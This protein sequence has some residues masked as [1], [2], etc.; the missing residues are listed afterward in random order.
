MDHMQKEQQIIT[1][2]VRNNDRV[3]YFIELT[4]LDT[5][6]VSKTRPPSRIYLCIQTLCSY[7][8]LHE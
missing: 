2:F 4:L 1:Q 6:S 7:H 3:I 8:I 5:V